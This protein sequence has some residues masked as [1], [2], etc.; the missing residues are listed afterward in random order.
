MPPLR[1][2]LEIFFWSRA[3][4]WLTLLLAYVVFEAR[5]ALPLHPPTTAPPPPTD[6]GWGFDLWARWDGGWYTHIAQDG[7]TDP[8]STTAFFPAYPMLVRA[9]GWLIGGHYVLA[10][11]IVSLIA[12]AVAFVLF[13]ELARELVGDDAARRALVFL[14]VFPAALFLGA[15]YSESLYLLLSAAAF[16]AA[17]RGRFALAGVAA[18]LAILTRPTGVMLLPAL[19]VLAWRAP[20]RARAFAGVALAVPIGAIWPLWLSA[21]FGHPLEFLGAERNEWQRHLSPAGP[22]GGAWHGLVAGW[23]GIEQLVAGG[24]RFPGADDALQ[25]AGL[26][27]EAL[28]AAVFAVVLGIVAWRRLGAAY[29]LFVLLSVALPLS[30]PT[31]I[32]PLLSMPRF[33]LGLFPVF[34]ALGA[35]AKGPRSNAILITCFAILLGLDLARWVE[36]QFVA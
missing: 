7:Y 22:L 17:V 16:L 12:A 35:I 11:V 29:G 9:L 18:G 26:N 5:Y 33:V 4:I 14:A 10:G 8:H 32:Y 30:T 24:N 27:L 15:V 34:I 13:H 21:A 31:A 1:R 3:A 36:W 23:R 20:S 2:P 25:A 6:V 28:A 19:A